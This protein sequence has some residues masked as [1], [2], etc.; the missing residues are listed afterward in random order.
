MP[1]KA[2][3]SLLA[4]FEAL[5][6]DY[7]LLIAEVLRSELGDMVNAGESTMSSLSW[8]GSVVEHVAE[9]SRQPRLAVR[10]VATRTWR[11][12]AT[13]SAGVRAC[14]WLVLMFLTDPTRVIAA[15]AVSHHDGPAGTRNNCQPE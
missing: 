1:S 14:P 5:V 4:D 6:A 11:P 9:A 3:R 13:A 10:L 7:A 12:G 8:P 15:D 2:G